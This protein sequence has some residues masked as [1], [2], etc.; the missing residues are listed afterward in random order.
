MAVQIDQKTLNIQEKLPSIQRHNAEID[1]RREEIRKLTIEHELH[2]A[3]TKKLDAETRIIPV[4]TI[5]RAMI[6]AAAM[7]AAGAAI[8][9]VFSLTRWPVQDAL[10][11]TLV[12]WRYRVTGHATALPCSA[13]SAIAS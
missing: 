6:A 13:Y 11:P 8:A 1:Q 2:R 3:E 9:K 10:L 12:A 5:F 7:L 4:S